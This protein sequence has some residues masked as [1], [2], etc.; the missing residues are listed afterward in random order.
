M[1]KQ[2]D[3]SVET[4][5]IDYEIRKFNGCTVKW[6]FVSTSDNLPVDLGAPP[7][8]FPSRALLSGV[9]RVREG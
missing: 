7:C 6:G 4:K 2:Y 9:Q 1:M 5:R 8:L 3:L